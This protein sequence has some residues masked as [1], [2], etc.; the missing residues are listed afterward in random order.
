MK[1]VQITGGLEDDGDHCPP[2]SDLE[3]MGKQ[4]DE[5]RT[6]DL[7]QIGKQV[8]E[9]R[10]LS[11]TSACGGASLR[12]RAQ[13]PL[14]TDAAAGTDGSEMADHIDYNQPPTLLQHLPNLFD[15]YDPDL[16]SLTHQPQVD[17][18]L[19]PIETEQIDELRSEHIQL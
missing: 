13:D 2:L 1:D 17:E 19:G 9:D 7:E 10:T 4:V 16:R 12:D 15:H 14:E 8:D 5:D 6:L 3:Q 18:D 11:E